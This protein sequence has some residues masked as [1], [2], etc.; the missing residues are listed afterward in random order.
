[1]RW[2][3]LLQSS[4]VSGIQ[5]TESGGIGRA[6]TDADDGAKSDFGKNLSQLSQTMPLLCWEPHTGPSVSKGWS[7]HCS[8]PG[9]TDLASLRTLPPVFCAATHPPA[10]AGVHQAHTYLGL[11]ASPDSHLPGF[12]PP[13]C[14][15]SNGTFSVRPFPGPLI[16]ITSLL[17]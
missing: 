13:L 12:S 15:C 4:G 2:F 1:M 9:P 6:S 3:L 11:G 14:L 10:V 5:P 16:E 7:P 17:S 8:L